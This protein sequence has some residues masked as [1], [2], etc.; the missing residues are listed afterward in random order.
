ADPLAQLGELAGELVGEQSIGREVAAV[1]ALERTDLA[2]LEALGMAENA[3]GDWLRERIRPGAVGRGSRAVAARRGTQRRGSGAA[4]EGI[5]PS[6]SPGQAGGV[7]V[8]LP[9]RAPRTREARPP[10]GE[11]RSGFRSGSRGF[12]LGVAGGTRAGRVPNRVRVATHQGPSRFA[13]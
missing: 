2:G 8:W 5:A 3:D 9:C 13:V 12:G 11:V 4:P 6:S 10:A 7:A 1:E